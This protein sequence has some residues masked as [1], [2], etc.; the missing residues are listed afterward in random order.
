VM[1]VRPDARF[2]GPAL[3][4]AVAPKHIYAI[5]CLRPHRSYWPHRVYDI[6]FYGDEAS[7]DTLV[8]AYRDHAVN[9]VHPFSN[10]LHPKDTCRLLYVQALRNSLNIVDI[11]FDVCMIHRG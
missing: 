1:R 5:N 11:D 8:G 7:M 6:F 3:H 9:E 10:G 2:Y 4:T